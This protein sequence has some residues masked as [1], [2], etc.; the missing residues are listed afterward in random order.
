MAP[1][2]SY[3]SIRLICSRPIERVVLVS[4]DSRNA[5][6]KARVESNTALSGIH[7]ASDLSADEAAA[8]ADIITTVTSAGTPV[9]DG[10]QVRPGTQHQ[11]G[12]RL[13]TQ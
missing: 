10:S 11:P 6:L 3:P 8:E 12:R 2:S 13:Q 1:G 7:V 4:R 5:A 9:F